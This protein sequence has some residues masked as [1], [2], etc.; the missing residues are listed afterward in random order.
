[1]GL[2][3]NNTPRLPASYQYDGG[4]PIYRGGTTSGPVLKPAA[5]GPGSGW[6]SNPA[7]PMG[8]QHLPIAGQHPPTLGNNA[9]SNAQDG[10]GNAIDADTKENNDAVESGHGRGV[11]CVEAKPRDNKGTVQGGQGNAVVAKTGQNGN[12]TGVVQPERRC[13]MWFFFF[14]EKMASANCIA[15]EI[16]SLDVCFDQRVIDFYDD[17]S[18]GSTE[19]EEL[20]DYEASRTYNIVRFTLVF[21]LVVEII[22]AVVL[23]R[24]YRTPLDVKSVRKIPVTDLRTCGGNMMIFFLAP[25]SWA[26]IYLFGGFASISYGIHASCDGNGGLG[27]DVYLSVSG[28]LMVLFGVVL[29]LASV[30]TLCV[31]FGSPSRCTDGCC[32]AIRRQVSDTILSKGALFEIFWI[33]QGVVW[34]Y[35][36]GDPT[37]TIL[38]VMV[39]SLGLAVFC[40]GSKV[41]IR[42]VFLQTD[43]N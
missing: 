21:G 42:W 43:S 9:T 32:H 31:S 37:Q 18:L 4:N 36:T 3:P 38:V 16:Y 6:G 25:F 26:V 35:R 39:V 19:V 41:A 30:L 10:Q 33:L 2:Q 20:I 7:P 28:V 23:S 40:S 1:M 27:L 11:G 8:G 29:L 22:S 24:A 13:R 14:V 5:G 12:G 17:D 34:S 15:F